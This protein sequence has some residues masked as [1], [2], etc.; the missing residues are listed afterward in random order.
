MPIKQ[1]FDSK[2]KLNKTRLNI[3][4][5]KMKKPMPPSFAAGWE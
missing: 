4:A 3:R 1:N 2:T 5:R